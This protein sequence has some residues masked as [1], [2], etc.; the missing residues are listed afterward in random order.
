MCDL[1]FRELI[2]NE[3][4][5]GK[6]IEGELIVGELS[7]LSVGELSVC[8]LIACDLMFREL[9]V[10]DFIVGDF[11]VG[12]LIRRRFR[13]E[14]L[15][16]R[17]WTAGI[18]HP[19]FPILKIGA[20]TTFEAPRKWSD[21]VEQCRRRHSVR[22]RRRCWRCLNWK[23][24]SLQF[25]DGV[26]GKISCLYHILLQFVDGFGVW[27]SRMERERKE[28]HRDEEKEKIQ[29]KGKSSESDP[30][31][32]EDGKNCLRTLKTQSYS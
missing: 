24:N 16:F 14:S 7:E 5:V 2:V 18:L 15:S 28:N 27:G 26:N 21:A 9:I 12:E 10:D 20:S 1:I 29:M 31:Y 13:S 30:D 4:I 22:P 32:E 25:V 23:F 8:E 19:K 3:L 11:I 6:L 17:R